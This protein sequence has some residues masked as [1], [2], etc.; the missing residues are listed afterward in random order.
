MA[1][2][3]G[4]YMD[5]GFNDDTVWRFGGC[6]IRLEDGT[7][8]GGGAFASGGPVI[9]ADGPHVAVG[10][11]SVAVNGS[12]NLVIT[13][14]GSFNPICIAHVTPDET[15]A[16]RGISCGPSV[17]TVTT[18]VSFSKADVQLDLTTQLGWDAVS[19]SS[20]NIWVSWGAPIVRGVGEASLA[21]QAIDLYT[22]L[23]ARVAALE[24][25]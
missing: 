20:S 1:N 19:G 9:I 16:A 12:G 22:A 23:E 15:L 14:D 5:S 6:A 8:S 11:V 18:V 7:V 21:Q 3:Y 24:G 2:E 17:G 25:N 10:V 13:T 4:D